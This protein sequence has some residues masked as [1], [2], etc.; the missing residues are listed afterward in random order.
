M[1]PR[2]PQPPWAQ[3]LSHSPSLGH[4][5]STGQAGRPPP[6][7]LRTPSPVSAMPIILHHGHRSCVC[8]PGPSSSGSR[9]QSAF[10]TARSLTE[11]WHRMSLGGV[12]AFNIVNSAIATL[13]QYF[14]SGP[15]L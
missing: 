4:L 9:W 6:E 5:L 2:P 12:S 8:F 15:G 11:G 7:D 13:V 10:T 14:S 3:K 1:P